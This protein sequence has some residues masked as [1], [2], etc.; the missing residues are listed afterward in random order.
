MGQR[1]PLQEAVIVT[2]DE[3]TVNAVEKLRSIIRT[4]TNVKDINVQQSLPGIKVSIKADYSQIGPDFGKKAPEIISKLMSESP[5]AVLKHIEKEGKFPLKIGKEIVNIVKEHL[6]VDRKVPEPYLEASFRTGLV[7]LN[8]QVG[9]D[10][11]AEGFARELMR[12]IQSLRKEAGLQKKDRITLFVR[13]DAELSKTLKVFYDTIKDKVGA[14]HMTISELD[15][16]KKHMF[17]S[18]EKVKDHEF[19]LFLEKVG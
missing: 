13:T 1:W 4:Q 14:E 19:E 6:I 3:K 18:R 15:P 2:K 10:L 8:K 17:Q 9:E 11:E 12:R 16:N 7:Y 5:E